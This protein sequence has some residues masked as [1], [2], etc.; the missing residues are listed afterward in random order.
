MGKTHNILVSAELNCLKWF[1]FVVH[2]TIP[3]SLSG[4]Y[5]EAGRAGRD[6][7]QSRCRVY[8]VRSTMNV[9][10]MFFVNS[11]LIRFFQTQKEIGTM[12]YLVEEEAKKRSSV[13]IPENKCVAYITV[14]QTVPP[15]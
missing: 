5:Q 15:I 7:K 13:S 9:Q 2:W 12:R 1:R 8:V 11:R 14:L 3:K 6:G 4:F 10:L